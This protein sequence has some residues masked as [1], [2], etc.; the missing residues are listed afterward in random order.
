MTI[1][2][3]I[4]KMID[5]YVKQYLPAI[6]SVD[7]YFDQFNTESNGNTD[8]TSNPKILIELGELEAIKMLGGV[9]NF[10][11]SITLHIGIDIFN[12]FKTKELVDKNIA[13]LDLLGEI[14]LKLTGLSS[15]NL[16]D[17]IRSNDIIIHNI[18]RSRIIPA[19]N[20]GCEM[21][22]VST[23]SNSSSCR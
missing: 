17:N 8:A 11:S 18:E 23:C 22:P 14:Y 19:S 15:F 3:Y 16:P 2:G 5:Y 20:T 21:I 9:Q 7:L 10:S 1:E 13:Y 4:Y 6:K 12:T